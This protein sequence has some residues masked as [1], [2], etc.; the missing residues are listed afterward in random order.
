MFGPDAC[1]VDKKMHFIMRHKH[2]KTGDYEEKHAKKATGNLD[3][4][5][6][7]K[8]HLFRLTVNSDNSWEVSVII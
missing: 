3:F 5:S 2:P 8:T 4:Y 1:G 6:D 7:K